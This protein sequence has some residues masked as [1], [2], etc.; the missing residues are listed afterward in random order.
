MFG[1]SAVCVVELHQPPCLLGFLQSGCAA[2]SGRPYS[3]PEIFTELRPQ[4]GILECEFNGRN[5]K[6]QLVSGIIALPLYL[7]RIHRRLFRQFPK[8]VGQLDLAIFTRPGFSK[9]GENVRR[10]HIATD[11][12]QIG[13]GFVRRWFLNET[14]DSM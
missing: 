8:C 2:S 6:S 5:E 11:D 9:N 12:R 14:L 10:Q 13:R 3:I 4:R 1:V 7:Q